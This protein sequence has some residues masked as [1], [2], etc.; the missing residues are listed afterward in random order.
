MY[1]QIFHSGNVVRMLVFSCVSEQGRLKYDSCI[2]YLWYRTHNPQ[3][4]WIQYTT[5]ILHNKIFMHTHTH[6]HNVKGQTYATLE[7]STSYCNILGRRP[8]KSRFLVGVSL[9][10]FYNTELALYRSKDWAGL[11]KRTNIYWQKLCSHVC[12]YAC[13][14]L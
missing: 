13:I 11:T 8:S 2:L 1:Q 5:R 14:I 10:C 6:T 12:L 4:F 7:R 3:H 9:K